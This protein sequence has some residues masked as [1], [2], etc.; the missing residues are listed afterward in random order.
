LQR[1]KP[2][3]NNSLE[4]FQPHCSGF[5]EV[6]AEK[7]GPCPSQAFKPVR[8]PARTITSYSCKNSI[9]SD[10]PQDFLYDADRAP[11]QIWL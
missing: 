9:A 4:T 6:K 3:A 2:L 10:L 11:G 1:E 7:V 5:K 8:F